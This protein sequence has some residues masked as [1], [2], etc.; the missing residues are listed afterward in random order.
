MKNQV[1][2]VEMKL[3]K[4]DQGISLVDRAKEGMGEVI[5]CIKDLSMTV[6]AMEVDELFHGKTS[7]EQYEQMKEESARLSDQTQRLS[8][9]VD[10]LYSGGFSDMCL[11][12][13]M[14]KEKCGEMV[15]LMGALIEK[16][17]WI[18]HHT[19]DYQKIEFTGSI[20]SHL[21]TLTEIKER[22]STIQRPFSKLDGGTRYKRLG[23]VLDCLE[24]QEHIEPTESVQVYLRKVSSLIEGDDQMSLSD[25]DRV[26]EKLLRRA[27]ESTWLRYIE[28]GEFYSPLMLLLSMDLDSDLGRKIF[29]C[30]QKKIR[31]SE[32]S[33]EKRYEFY[34]MFIDMLDIHCDNEER[35]LEI[36]QSMLSELQQ[37]LGYVGPCRSAEYSVKEVRV[38]EDDAK[39]VDS[40]LS[41]DCKEGVYE[42]S[43]SNDHVDEYRI[44]QYMVIELM[45]K[46][47]LGLVESAKK[48]GKSKAEG[49]LK[50]LTLLKVTEGL[51]IDSYI[52]HTYRRL[53]VIIQAK[54]LAE[55][56]KDS[57]NR[58]CQRFMLGL[59]MAPDIDN[60]LEQFLQD[61]RDNAVLSLDELKK[62]SR[63]IDHYIDE[64]IDNHWAFRE[65][66]ESMWRKDGFMFSSHSGSCQSAK[67]NEIKD[68]IEEEVEEEEPVRG[69][70]SVLGKKHPW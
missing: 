41:E 18:M 66:I 26:K 40:D 69:W 54:L 62:A 64:G 53:K 13:G 21:Q 68:E 67:Y 42:N 48:K 24:T 17:I 33:D 50:Q 39:A 10:D 36:I 46:A 31:G 32:M 60:E 7:T 2:Q 63:M 59:F 9:G 57:R 6:E 56:L 5:S 4:R 34:T 45:L 35:K 43:F 23:A 65:I 49:L 12:D 15:D 25:H 8:K 51:A 3:V 58:G 1:E 38:N 14:G 52:L 47:C 55:Q 19:A 16:I 29:I 44:N 22:L 27:K 28:L 11:Q 30:L 70:L 20:I 61:I 37:G